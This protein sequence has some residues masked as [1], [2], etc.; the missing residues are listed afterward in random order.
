[1]VTKIINA[2]LI[3]DKVIDGQSLDACVPQPS[4]IKMITENPANTM[5]IPNKG[6]LAVGFDADFV[7]FDEE[8]NVKQ[9]IVSGKPIA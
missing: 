3:T 6:R 8:I 1:M 4:A 5:K 2:R 9:V 7:L